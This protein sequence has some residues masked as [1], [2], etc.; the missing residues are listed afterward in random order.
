MV[1]IMYKCAPASLQYSGNLRA[2]S[3]CSQI[4]TVS[5]KGLGLGVTVTVKV[6]RVSCCSYT[7]NL[8]A[9]FEGGH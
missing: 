8:E 3:A 7:R 1:E 4:Q 6:S 9:N 2:S 5:R